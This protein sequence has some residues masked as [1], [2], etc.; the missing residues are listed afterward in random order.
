MPD[1]GY[2]SAD[3]LADLRWEY[4]VEEDELPEINRDEDYWEDEYR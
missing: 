4:G 3:I 1:F 2:V